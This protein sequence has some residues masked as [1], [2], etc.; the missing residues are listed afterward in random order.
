MHIKFLAHGTGDPQKAADYLLA[1][2]DYKGV[3]RPEV[4]VLRGDPQ[5]VARVVDSLPQ[6]H[7]Y[8]SGVIAWA[9]EDAPSAQE[10]E[11]VLDDF[12]RVAFAG[13]SPD[14]YSYAAISHGGHVHLF[15]A[16]VDLLTGK[17]FNVAPPSWKSAFYPMRDY[18]NGTKGWARPQ[19][20]SRARLL[21]MPAQ[22]HNP[23]IAK[24]IADD[25]AM[26]HELIDVEIAFDVEPD[27]ELLI[28][29]W[30]VG[31]VHE[32]KIVNHQD[33]LN[34]LS[35]EG[36][37]KQAGRA[38]LIFLPNGGHQPLKLRGRLFAEDF[39]A[40]EVFNGPAIR[41]SLWAAGR[42]E[43]DLAFAR[44][45]QQKMKA[46]I[47]SRTEY[48]QRVYKPKMGVI[49][50][51]STLGHIRAGSTTAVRRVPAPT[52]PATARRANSIAGPALSALAAARAAIEHCKQL[53]KKSMQLAV[54]T[55]RT[56]S[57][58]NTLK[59]KRSLQAKS[60]IPSPTHNAK[61]SIGPT[62]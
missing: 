52:Q 61:G 13:L 25:L 44:A 1:H 31:L 26:G 36:Q 59:I 16:K 34:A 43:P 42:A 55:L 24:K 58:S 35:Q 29:E 19:D 45:A 46:V 18:W 27:P 6:V 17:S 11:D 12:E 21:A 51:R 33:V 56:G 48:N 62:P 37:V 3:P 5:Q 10:V 15:I 60:V 40:Q 50:R 53:L 4:Q 54:K 9:H 57:A 2:S 20:P 39:D 47:A 22:R 14:R 38:S 23:T 49:K 41:E 30:L 28:A 32:K 8:T 7:R